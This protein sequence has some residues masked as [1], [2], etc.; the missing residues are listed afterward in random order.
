MLDSAGG[1]ARRRLAGDEGV[2][3]FITADLMMFAVFFAVFMTARLDEVALF[4][5]SRQRLNPAIGLLNTAIL[6]SSSWLVALA[7]HAARA[8]RREAVSRLLGLGI[9]V[10]SGFA[11]SKACEYTAKISAGVTLLTNHFFMY[12]FALTGLHFV[13]FL[14]GMAVLGVCWRKSRHEAIDG[15]F[16]VW[17]ESAGCYWHMVDLLWIF[18]FPMLYLLRAA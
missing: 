5:Q 9:L 18:L 4:E 7:V 14:A 11:V 6:L 13:H 2:W 3:F 1:A 12:Y 8:G 10:G 15:R 16:L 17:L